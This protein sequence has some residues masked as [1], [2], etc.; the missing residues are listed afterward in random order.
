MGLT[1]YGLGIFQGVELRVYDSGF[2][3]WDFGSWVL[4][5]KVYGFKL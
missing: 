2:R 4:V 3:V 1:Y 5:F